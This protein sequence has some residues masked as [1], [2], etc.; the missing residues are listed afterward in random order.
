MFDLDF[1]DFGHD[2]A[3][4]FGVDHNVHE[5]SLIENNFDGHIFSDHIF[6]DDM[7]H[8]NDHS[9]ENGDL[10]NNFEIQD[11]DSWHL[12]VFGEPI[13]DSLVWHQQTT[14]FTC[15]I[16]SSEMILKMYGL[17]I[18]EAQLVYEATSN[19]FLTDQGIALE[20]IQSI[21]HNHGV[22]S[23]LVSGGMDE[24]RVE[25]EQ[26]HKLVIALDSG[27]IWGKD[28]PLEDF[29]GENADHAVVLTGIDTER[30]VIFLNDPGHPNGQAMEIDIDTFKDAWDDSENQFIATKSSP[31]F[32]T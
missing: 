29:F 6:P 27:E 22:D 4:D 28:S 10:H 24:L 14:P 26:G 19:G 9:F 3:H 16:V 32:L 17:D 12:D 23:Q 25:L 1:F 21:L 7:V 18:S 5:N 15:G 11:F 20:G 13:Q 8:S 2:S 30:G 31:D